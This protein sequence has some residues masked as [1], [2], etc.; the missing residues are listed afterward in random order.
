V[1]PHTNL[2][3]I[4]QGLD[5]LWRNNIDPSK[6]TLGLGWYGRSFTLADPSCTTPGCVFTSGGNAGPC[7]G[8]SGILSNAEIMDVIASNSL[9]PSFDATAAIKWITWDT[10]QWVSYDDGETVQMK[11]NYANQRCLGGTMVWAVVSINSK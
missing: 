5:L 7:T 6:V 3:E 1:R 9:T 10:N 4:E 2:T 11:I 8:A